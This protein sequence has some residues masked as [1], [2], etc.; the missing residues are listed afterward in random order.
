MSNVPPHDDYMRLDYGR[1]YLEV[2]LEEAEEEGF[3]EGFLL[4][5]RRVVEVHALNN[6]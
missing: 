6:W 4:A 3:N 1:G 2:S 5:V